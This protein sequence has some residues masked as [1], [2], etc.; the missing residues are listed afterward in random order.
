M[1]KLCVVPF[2]SESTKLTLITAQ[3]EN[4]LIKELPVQSQQQ[5][6]QKQVVAL[7]T[8]TIKTPEQRNEL[9]LF[10]W[11]QR[12]K[13]VYMKKKLK[14]KLVSTIFYQFF[15]FS[16]NYRPSKTEKCFFISSKKLFSFSRYSIFCNFFPSFPHFPDS[17]GQM[18]VE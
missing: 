13:K 10:K 5:K 17:K 16:S 14:L 2:S 3:I 12:T 8:L 11:L 7:P 6:H 18:E 15:I 1:Q 4:L 9:K